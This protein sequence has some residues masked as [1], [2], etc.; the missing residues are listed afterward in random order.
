[1]KQK[2]TAGQKKCL[3]LVREKGIFWSDVSVFL[4]PVTLV[5]VAVLP[6][7]VV[8]IPLTQ[9]I[10][11]FSGQKTNKSSF[12]A[13]RRKAGIL[14]TRP[15]RKTYGSRAPSRSRKMPLSSIV[16]NSS[17]ATPRPGITSSSSSSQSGTST[18][19][20]SCI[21]GC[22]ISSSPDCKRRSS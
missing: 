18:K 19:A 12:A 11:T 22:G 13:L 6:R 3:P 2:K 7:L 17:P 14:K 8:I 20:R 9:I 21:R 10:A 4:R 15:S 5:R 16:D 1:M